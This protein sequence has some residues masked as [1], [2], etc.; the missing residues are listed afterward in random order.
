MLLNLEHKLKNMPL[1]S[2][3]NLSLFLGK[4]GASLNYWTKKLV[5]EGVLIK[6]KSGIY[7]SSYYVDLVSQRPEDKARYLEY[8]ANQLCSPSYVSLEYV[9]AKENVIPEAVFKLTSV[10]LKSTRTYE[11]KL[12]AFV[13]RNIKEPLFSGYE[14]ITWRDKQIRLATTQKALADWRH[15]NPGADLSRSA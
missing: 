2:K 4:Q 5:D 11:T 13:Y 15:L 8:L 7:A 1:L 9:L 3:Q 12:G 14:I 6:L 10:T